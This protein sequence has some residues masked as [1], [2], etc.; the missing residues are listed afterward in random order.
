MR[1]AFVVAIAGGIIVAAVVAMYASQLPTQ[2]YS[3]S[4]DALK[5]EQSIFTNARVVLSNTGRMPLTNV[6]VNYGGNSTEFVGTM[7]PGH[8]TTVSPPEGTQLTFVTV[9]ADHDIKIVQAYRA[10]IK[11]PGMIGS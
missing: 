7:A 8:K 1:I 5:D 11:L 3:L 4:V 2:D 6:M 9:T 10:P